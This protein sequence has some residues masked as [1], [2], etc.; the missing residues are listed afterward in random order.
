MRVQVDKEVLR[1]IHQTEYN[2]LKEVVALFEKHGLRYTIYCGTLLGAVRHKGFIPWDD[3]IDLA[4]P[5]S[6]YRKFL[7]LGDELETR[8]SLVHFDN[9]CNF[10]Y[11]WARVFDEQTTLMKKEWSFYPGHYGV[12]IDIYPFVG[13]FSSKIGQSIQ[14]LL[15]SVAYV[16]RRAGK[17]GYIP[18]NKKWKNVVL[19]VFSVVPFCI[20]NTAALFCRK[21]AIL[22]PEKHS[23]IGT[24]DAVAFRGKYDT[25]DWKEMIR[26]PFEGSWFSAPAKYDKLLRIMYG[27]YMILPP[28][29]L[30]YAHVEEDMIIDMHRS[31][32]EYVDKY[33]TP[34]ILL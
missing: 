2:M 11:N 31:Y 14:N 27:E 28:E 33:A 4:M 34:G 22:D 24:I 32:R 13:A 8:Y 12:F 25:A 16:M 5:L 9:S 23:R 6:D 20:R 30:R 15:F 7:Q 18:T 17:N 3:D 29:N 10:P 21:I 1:E 26:L 19:R